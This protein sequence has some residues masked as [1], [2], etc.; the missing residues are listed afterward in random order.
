MR[1]NTAYAVQLALWDNAMLAEL[2]ESRIMKPYRMY[3]SPQNPTFHRRVL[4]DNGNNSIGNKLATCRHRYSANGQ[5][6]NEKQT[7]RAI[8][9]PP[10]SHPLRATSRMPSTILPTSTSRPKSSPVYFLHLSKFL[11]SFTRRKRYLCLEGTESGSK[12]GRGWTLLNFARNVSVSVI[13]SWK[14]FNTDLSRSWHN[15]S[16]FWNFSW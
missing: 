6:W 4:S 16:Q 12:P 3:D 5:Q 9:S 8:C 2:Q 15:A 10:T 11:R 13:A 1:D 14:T 7:W